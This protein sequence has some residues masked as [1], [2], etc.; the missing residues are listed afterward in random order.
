MEVN[1]TGIYLCVLKQ[2]VMYIFT[3]FDGK[4]FGT[5]YTAK[6]AGVLLC[7]NAIRLNPFREDIELVFRNDVDLKSFIWEED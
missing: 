3:T 7:F 2:K 5:S 1:F 6:E 4:K